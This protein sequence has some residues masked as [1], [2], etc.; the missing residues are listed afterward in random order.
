[1]RFLAIYF[2]NQVME[3]LQ[4]RAPKTLSLHFKLCLCILAVV[5][6]DEAKPNDAQVSREG[7]IQEAVFIE[8]SEDPWQFHCWLFH[9]NIQQG[10][11]IR[12]GQGCLISLH[13]HCLKWLQWLG[14]LQYHACCR[15]VAPVPSCIRRIAYT[16]PSS[17]AACLPN[18]SGSAAQAGRPLQ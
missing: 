4:A 13:N 16:P 9:S 18:P 11:F 10:F 15:C 8:H 7:R 5:V 14:Q 3:Q 2:C 17:L 1:M 12:S 6:C